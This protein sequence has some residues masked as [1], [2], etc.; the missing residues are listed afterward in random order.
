MPRERA[1]E[2][3]VFAHCK[4]H[5][6][7]RGWRAEEAAAERERTWLFQVTWAEAATTQQGA[8]TRKASRLARVSSYSILRKQGT[9]AFGLGFCGAGG[10]SRAWLCHDG[11]LSPG[12]LHC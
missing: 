12:E 9:V 4:G 10:G 11:G 1:L 6:G 7:R 2:S 3:G 8:A 5:L